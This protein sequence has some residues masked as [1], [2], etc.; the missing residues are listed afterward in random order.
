MNRKI[1]FVGAE[2]TPSEGSTFVGGHVN[3]V[4]S[5]CKGLSNL[6]WEIHIVTTASRF[7]KEAEFD[8]P[9][10][11]IHVIRTDGKYKSLSYE[12]AFLIK[13]FRTIENLNSKEPF[14]LV[15]AHSGYFG[16]AVIPALIK[17]KLRVPALF[18]L[19]CPAS[20]LPR[21]LPMENYGIKILSF[22][23][24]KIIAVTENVKSSL[25]KCGVNSEKIEIIPSCFDEE[26][27][28]PSEE[29][30]KM[31]GET[32]N[33]DFEVRKVL[34][35]GNIDERKGLDVFLSA[36]KYVLRT[37]PEA[38]FI[39]TLH[40]PDEILQRA[41]AIATSVLGSA[42]RIFGIVNNMA[43][44][45]ADADVVVAPFRST[46]GISDIPLVVLEAMALG[47]PVVVS[48]LL[49]AKE[50]I[51]DGENGILVDLNHPDK[52]A[53]AIT[54][55]L[56]DPGMREKISSKAILS[57]KRFSHSEISQRLSDLYKRVLENG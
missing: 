53:R 54:K 28:K 45:M 6:A 35:A 10:A 27:F 56:N 33:A 24:D 39:V 37:R 2:I 22:S 50:V 31:V 36:A 32:K 49:G 21:R 25:I 40:E 13:A 15:H 57:V 46:E 43:E 3:T 48:S 23:L 11:K 52:L 19:Y 20:L 51:N 55:L 18:S 14:D 17:R 44:L 1:C 5:L 41:K 16:P 29:N 30:L 47:K 42:V 9:W 12:F 34:Y 26:A 38:R 4:V 7:L 8:F